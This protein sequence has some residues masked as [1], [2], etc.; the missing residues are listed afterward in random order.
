MLA[1]TSGFRKAGFTGIRGMC[2]FHVTKALKPRLAKLKNRIGIEIKQDIYFLQLSQNPKLFFAGCDSFLD[3]WSISVESI[4]NE[5]YIV[6]AEEPVIDFLEYF[7]DEWI[8]SFP[9]WFEGFCDPNNVGTPSTNN[10]NEGIN[11]TIKNEETLREQLSLGEF[12]VA[13]FRMMSKWSRIRDPAN[14][15]P[16]LF[17]TVP[18][19]LLDVWTNAFDWNKSGIE[20]VGL[21]SE[22]NHYYVKSSDS[23]LGLN[24]DVILAYIKLM[25]EA[26]FTNFNQFCS[27]AFGYYCIKMP[28]N[29]ND[30][31]WINGTCT[32]PAYYKR[33]ICKH[34][35]GIALRYSAQFPMLCDARNHLPNTANR[36][37]LNGVARSSGRPR[38]VPK[39]LEF[40]PY[41]FTS[42]LINDDADNEIYSEGDIALLQYD[43]TEYNSETTLSQTTTDRI[44][45]IEAIEHQLVNFDSNSSQQTV[46]TQLNSEVQLQTT[47]FEASAQTQTIAPSQIRYNKDGKPSKK[48]GPK[49]K[50]QVTGNI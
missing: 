43:V 3:K 12:G 15:N 40:L 33:Y 34:I 49:P 24:E 44:A 50:K 17:K 46:Y 35:L 45:S 16:K 36:K 19:P 1:I 37:T 26:K 10:G 42:I 28:G 6:V 32:C 18:T 31:N 4:D 29:M 47:Q 20:I 23:E 8:V 2:W 5:A 13:A 38:L 9:N 11:A 22:P 30:G 21:S 25:S 39:A 27:T 14:A 48:R 41:K 7:D